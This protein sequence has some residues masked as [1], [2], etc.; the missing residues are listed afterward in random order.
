MSV[1]DKSKSRLSL[2]L[3]IGVFVVPVILAKLALTNQWFN[4]GV[5]NQGALLDQ[6]LDLTELGVNTDAI[7]KQWLIIYGLPQTCDEK[8]DQT[9]FSINQSYLALG[10]ETPRVTPVVMDPVGTHQA[11][12]T[13]LNQQ[14]W[15]IQASS[16]QAK[17]RVLP[18]QIYIADPLGNVMMIYPRPET[19]QQF[20]QFSKD[21]LSDMRKLL[22]YSRIG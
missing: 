18:S 3:V 15:Q 16:L 12:I 4:E 21:L 22:K 2:V 5:T 20:K 7:D 13:R 1:T 6:P 14:H 10:R 8:C 19:E 17:L 11:L 9:L